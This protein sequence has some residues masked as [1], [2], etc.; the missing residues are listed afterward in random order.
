MRNPWLDLPHD[1]PF[2]LEQ[3][4]AIIEKH[5]RTASAERFI[6]LNCLPEPFLG[7]PDAPVILLNL[8]PGFDPDDVRFHL[9]DRAF[10]ERSRANLRHEAQDYAFYLL[11]PAIEEA[12]GHRWW[13]SHLR[14]LV[15]ACGRQTVARNV[16]CVE[17]FPYH[18]ERFGFNGLVPSQEYSFYLVR[19]AIRRSAL[20]VQMRSRRIWFEAIPELRDYPH[21]CELSS[22]QS[23]YV[24]PRN[25]PRYNQVVERIRAGRA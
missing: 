17:H 10:I 20:I 21:W 5:N 1:P 4:R 7:K 9:E 2:V 8:N 12:P 3:D 18:S 13:T 19:E 11:D 24:S 14:G 15:E 6:H 23:A 16:L 25:C 22:P